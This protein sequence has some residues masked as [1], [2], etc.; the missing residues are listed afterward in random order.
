ML[1]RDLAPAALA[2]MAGVSRRRVSNVLCGNDTSRPIREAINRALGEKI[3]IKP[4]S[5]KV[6]PTK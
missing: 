3:F 2:K 5:P 4:A 1:D 6:Q